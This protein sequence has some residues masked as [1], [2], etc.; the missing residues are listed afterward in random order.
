MKKKKFYREAKHTYYFKVFSSYLGASSTTSGMSSLPM[1]MS[2]RSVRREDSL[3]S[4]WD[5]RLEEVGCRGDLG[6]GNVDHF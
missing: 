2:S 6:K 1:N 3:S 5:T 4:H